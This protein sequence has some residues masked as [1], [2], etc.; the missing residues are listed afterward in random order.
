M[1][2]I[3]ADS[4]FCLSESFVRH[5][6]IPIILQVISFGEESYLEGLEFGDESFIHKPQTA[7]NLP[8]TA[9]P[10]P[11]L[12]V[13][14]FESS[15][16]DESILCILSSAAMSGTLRPVTVGLQ[17]APGGCDYLSIMHA[18]AARETSSCFCQKFDIDKLPTL[19]VPPAVV[20]HGSPG[21]LAFITE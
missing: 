6:N 15:S 2:K 21:V 16:D 3:I 1:V 5:H 20:T 14:T 19:A 4:I 9:D 11:E 12:F 17:M 13:V 7:K 10:L 18:D 8:E